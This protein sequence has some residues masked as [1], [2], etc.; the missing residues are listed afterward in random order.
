MKNDLDQHFTTQEIPK[1]IRD[2]FFIWYILDK[3]AIPHEYVLRDLPSLNDSAYWKAYDQLLPYLIG[4]PFD[5]KDYQG[6]KVG[7]SVTE[8]EIRS[9]LESHSSE[10]K[11]RKDQFCWS[12]RN[13]SGDISDGNYCDHNTTTTDQDQSKANRYQNLIN[14]MKQEIPESSIQTYDTELTLTDIQTKT[15]RYTDY[16][17]IFKCFVQ[18]QMN[19]SLN[20]II[21]MRQEWM[22]DSHGLGIRGDEVSEMLR[23]CK[24]AFFKCSTFVG[25]QRLIEETIAFVEAPNRSLENESN[26]QFDNIAV[27]II[28]VSG[29]GKTALMSKVASEMYKRTGGT[30]KII[31]RFCGTSP[32]SKNARNLTTSIC[33]QIEFLFHV[34][35][36]KSTS[37]RDKSY[38]DLVAYFHSLLKEH[39]VLLFIDSL[40]QLTD[41]NQ[42]RSQ[43]SFLKNVQP[44]ADT[45]IIV[46]SL[47]DEPE[48][49]PIS[50]LTYMYFC[51]TRLSVAKV[52]RVIVEMSKGRVMEESMEIVNQLL[53]K[54]NRRL[55]EDQRVIVQQKV[56]EEPEKTALYIHLAVGVIQNWTSE[57]NADDA[58]KGGVIKLIE[59]L[60]NTLEQQYGKELVRAALAFLTFSV[61]G[62]TDI[63]ME[64]LLSLHDT[65]LKEVFQYVTPT[66]RRLPT[67]V[68]QRLKAA[69]DGLI[70]EGDHG[71]LLW[72][73]RQLRETAVR[74]YEV[75]RVPST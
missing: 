67:H 36:I 69:M 72:F 56:R 14:Y 27:S 13:L 17:Q 37:F 38:D 64:D 73:H 70:T 49:N 71:C 18:Q 4:L 40:D 58:L 8:Y 52:P 43:I 66:V 25:R 21:E 31:I 16:F 44:H 63:E 45:R 51:D 50:G 34:Q 61:K 53:E 74:Y 11:D 1:D 2:F 47:P 22:K 7:M 55:Q 62:V 28:G 19:D 48:K 54:K 10:S 15:P 26:T 33:R 57:V 23:H 32:Q 9:A 46:S 3:N 59:Q 20:K 35:E 65:V 68:W 24:F 6:L 30:R 41:E 12:F 42:G 39:P 75:F 29:A 5:T 60:Y